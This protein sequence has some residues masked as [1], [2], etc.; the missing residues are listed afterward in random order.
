M[1]NT[2]FAN[3]GPL[4][5]QQHPFKQKKK[6]K[7]IRDHKIVLLYYNNYT[8]VKMKRLVKAETRVEIILKK[9]ETI[10]WEGQTG[11]K[12]HHVYGFRGMAF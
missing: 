9:K 8:G 1:S 3:Q 5:D 7:K 4:A 11:L 10:I 12:D 2:L 6:K